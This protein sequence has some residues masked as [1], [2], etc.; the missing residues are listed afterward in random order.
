MARLIAEMIRQ[1]PRLLKRAQKTMQ[2][3]KKTLRPIPT[4]IMEWDEILR[5]NTT[6]KVLQLLTDEG[7]L[8]NRLRQSDPFCGVLSE[9][10]RLEFLRKYEEE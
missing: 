6:V 2:N 10:Q 7:E 3:W 9:R 8:G 4:A 1:E 5:K